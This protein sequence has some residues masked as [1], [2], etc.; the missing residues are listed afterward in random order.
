MICNAM[1]KMPR[2]HVKDA[3]MCLK[4]SNLSLALRVA[5]CV[6]CV[7][8]RIACVLPDG[9]ALGVAAPETDKLVKQPSDV[10]R[11]F[12]DNRVKLI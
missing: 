12:S 2:C 6:H 3:Y 9:T 4:R 7:S 5:C 10:S 11:R 1:L 8:Q